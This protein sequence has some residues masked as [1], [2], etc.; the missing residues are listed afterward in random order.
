MTA[1]ETEIERLTK[2]LADTEA[3]VAR[4]RRALVRIRNWHGEFPPTDLEWPD[5]TQMSYSAVYGSNGERDYM[6]RLARMT[7][8][9]ASPD[10]V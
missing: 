6:R 10:D 5:G 8:A 9:G 1:E 4:L 7:L 2:K 3:E